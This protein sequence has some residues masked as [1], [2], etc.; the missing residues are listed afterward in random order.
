MMSPIGLWTVG[1]KVDILIGSDWDPQAHIVVATS[2]SQSSQ[3]LKHTLLYCLSY[4]KW[5]YYFK[6]GRRAVLK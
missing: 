6:N 1:F 5:S 2:T 3:A 4:S